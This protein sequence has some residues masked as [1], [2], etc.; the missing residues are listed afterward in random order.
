MVRKAV[1]ELYLNVKIRSQD[2][3][4]GMTEDNMDKERKK[5]NMVDTL[6]LIDYIK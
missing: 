6:D 5:L 3:I 2:D 1:L 4:L